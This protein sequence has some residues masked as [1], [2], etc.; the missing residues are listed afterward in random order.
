VSASKLPMLSAAWWTASV[1]RRVGLIMVCVLCLTSAAAVISLR[2]LAALNSELDHTVE[3]QSEA[4]QLVGLMLEE[5][6]RLSD[7]ARAAVH[8][9]T[10]E[11]RAEALV[12]LESSKQALGEHVDRI[13]AQ[14]DDVPEL[15]AA[16]QDGFSSFV[17]SAVKA[18]RLIQSGRQEEA[19]REL[20][21]SFNP[22]LLAYVLMTVSGISQ[23]TDR[24][25]QAVAE[26]GHA[27]YSKTLA[28]L[29]PILFAV[30]SSVILGQ[31]LLR[32]TVV[33]PVRRAARAAQML[34][35][36]D[37][38]VDL[39]TTAN[40]ECGDMLRRMAALR[41]QLAS[42]VEAMETTSHSVVNTSDQLA[43]KNQELAMR[44]Q[45][46]ARALRSASRALEA[47]NEMSLR[48][49]EGAE[50]VSLEVQAASTAAQRGHQVIGEVVSTM[51]ETVE[52][53]RKIAATVGMIHEIAFKTNMLSLNAAVEAARA[54]E[55]GKGFAVVA[56]EVRTL[57][58]KSA[59]AAKEIEALIASSMSTVEKGSQLGVQAGAAIDDIVRQVRS[60]ADRMVEISHASREQSVRAGEV[61]SAMGDIDAGTQQNADMVA[62]AATATETLR[63]DA[64]A[65][66]DR[67]EEF[68]HHRSGS[69]V[70]TS[71]DRS[72]T[73]ERIAA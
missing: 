9:T 27:S 16:L 6:R 61:S 57:A 51:R 7:S 59:A 44:T 64:H 31:W 11:E 8:A 12:A 56:A 70:Q 14:L 36:G 48:S 4:A 72:P 60:A 71:P 47:L 29:V 66:T 20:L 35:G 52:A 54:G 73:R 33:Q 53:S 2:G 19:E 25:V 10:P 23:D 42:M 68:T 28:I 18:S 50:R 30:A 69:E 38:A 40:D 34:A 39:S 55:Q 67:I 17:I 5:S 32:R 21:T 24:S 63:D 26:S 37:F 22:K 3:Y 1:S 46:Q 45:A 13:S 65:L 58:S 62:Q 43:V 15:Q 49:A 41:E